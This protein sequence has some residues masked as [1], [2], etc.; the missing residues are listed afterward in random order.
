LHGEKEARENGVELNV[1]T[2][3]T[4]KNNE[5]LYKDEFYRDKSNVDAV[6]CNPSELK[7]LL[8][9]HTNHK[10]VICLNDAVLEQVLIVCKELKLSIPDDISIISFDDTSISRQA[11]P[12]ITSVLVPKNAMGQGAV[13]LLSEIIEKKR[14]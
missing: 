3:T 14:K 11:T 6:I 2:L 8:I 13:K 1:K 5:S 7:E 12:P 4:S 10:A 9:N